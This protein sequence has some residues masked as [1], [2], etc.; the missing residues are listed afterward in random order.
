ML[1]FNAIQRIE[2]VSELSSLV[3]LDLA[4]NLVRKVEGIKGL[5]NVQHFDL[6]SNHVSA[7]AGEAV[8]ARARGR[9]L[10]EASEGKGKESL[11]A[12]PL[13]LLAALHTPLSHSSPLL[14]PSSLCPLHCRSAS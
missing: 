7:G 2:G 12:A 4:H 11:T 8:L 3:R 10:G 9:G 1:T 5:V 14:A 6:S 13:F